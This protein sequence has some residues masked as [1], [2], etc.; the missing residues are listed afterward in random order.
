MFQHARFSLDFLDIWSVVHAMQDFLVSYILD[1]RLCFLFDAESCDIV[2]L[3]ICL[4]VTLV[5]RK[6]LE[7]ERERGREREG[8]REGERG[9]CV[10][11]CF[12]TVL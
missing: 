4:H 11:G 12:H 6:G 8:E 5:V 9:G 10:G 1:S 2:I 7:R 3:A